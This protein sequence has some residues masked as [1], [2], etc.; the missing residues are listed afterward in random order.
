MF[1]G[2]RSNHL[3]TIHRED[4]KTQDTDITMEVQRSINQSA[5]AIKPSFIIKVDDEDDRIGGS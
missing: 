3:L 2:H 4:T 5:S 1:N